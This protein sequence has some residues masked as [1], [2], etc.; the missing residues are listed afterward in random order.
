MRCGDLPSA[1]FDNHEFPFLFKDLIA[2]PAACPARWHAPRLMEDAGCPAGPRARVHKALLVRRRRTWFV[3]AA[4]AAMDRRRQRG[5]RG[6]LVRVRIPERPL[7]GSSFRWSSRRE[8][9]CG[10]FE[11]RPNAVRKDGLSKEAVPAGAGRQARRASD[12][13]RFRAIGRAAG[14]PARMRST[15]RCRMRRRVQPRRTHA[16][17]ARSRRTPI[18]AMRVARRPLKKR[19]R[20]CGSVMW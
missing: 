6:S 20:I 3:A 18:R 13:L 9:V 19:T 17:P 7:F 16:P 11:S 10:G 5:A 8:P 2:F 1:T 15:T 14:R 12:R 4:H